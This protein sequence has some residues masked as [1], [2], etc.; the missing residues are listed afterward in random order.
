MTSLCFAFDPLPHHEDLD[1]DKEKADFIVIPNVGQVDFYVYNVLLY[2]LNQII[3][4]LDNL[5]VS[6]DRV[7][8]SFLSHSFSH[9]DQHNRPNQ[10]IQIATP[11]DSLI[12]SELSRL[13]RRKNGRSAKYKGDICLI[14][15]SPLDAIRWFLFPFLSLSLFLSF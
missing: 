4:S 2:F 10:S 9:S 3:Q 14:A 7:C 12:P 8:F 6:I 1:R 13:Q 11:L 5:F 15:G